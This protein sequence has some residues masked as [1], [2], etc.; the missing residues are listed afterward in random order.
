MQPF[1]DATFME[2]FGF[3]RS[4]YGSSRRGEELWLMELHV[5]VEGL[6]VEVRYCDLDE[7][8]KSSGEKIL[9][10]HKE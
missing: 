9:S 5:E 3:S 7:Q 8:V 10:L 4:C 2:L 1:G 6:H